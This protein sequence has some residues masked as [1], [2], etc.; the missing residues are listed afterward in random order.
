MV[1]HQNDLIP[2]HQ[3]EIH[4]RLRIKHIKIRLHWSSSIIYVQKDSEEEN[5]AW[6]G[7][8]I[9]IEKKYPA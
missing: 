6:L 4:C 2:N 3:L 7:V 8:S 1:C 5:T 9:L